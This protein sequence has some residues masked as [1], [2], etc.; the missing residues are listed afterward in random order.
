MSLAELMS[1]RRPPVLAVLAVAS[2]AAGC[3]NTETAS[4]SAESSD[5]AGD[6]VV[7]TPEAVDP[8]A[9]RRAKAAEKVGKGQVVQ[10]SGAGQPKTY[11]GADDSPSP[12]AATDDEVKA[13]LRQARAQ[14]KKFR[15]FLGGGAFAQ[16]GPRAKVLPDG[17]AVAPEDA[18]QPVQEVIQAANAIAKMP[19]KW[20]GGHGAWRDNGYDCSGSVSFALAGAGLLDAPMASGGFMNWGEEGPGEWITIYAGPGHMYM[21]VAGLRFD[22][23]GA[24]GA[25]TRWQ[26]ASRGM[27][28]LRVRHIPGL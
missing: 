12:G 6:D 11:E 8:A 21:V 15:R 9:V 5:K 3:G 19:Y 1:P 2:L 20:G 17:T 18:P 28:G 4:Q 22:T 14:L 25:G 27:R 10:L 7:L 13:D 16:T 23:S 24:K 26:S